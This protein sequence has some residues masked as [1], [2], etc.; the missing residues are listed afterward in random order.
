[1]PYHD[2][3]AMKIR[4]IGGV[5]YATIDHPPLNLLDQPLLEELGRFQSALSADESVRVVVFDSADPDFFVAHGDMSIARHPEA[6]AALA[7]QEP[8]GRLSPMI[9]MFEAYRALPQITIAK[10]RGRARGAG[11]EFLLALDLRFAA[12]ERAWF[13]QPEVSMG[14]LPGAGGTQ[15]LPRAVGRARA[16]EIIAGSDLFDADLAE[17]YGLINRALPPDQ[18]DAFTERLASR[19]ASFPPAAVTAAKRAVEAGVL[20]LDEGLRVE[21]ALT[22]T[23]F[24]TPEALSLMSRALDAGAQTREGEFVLESLMAALPR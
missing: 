3:A 12:S 10:V 1:M 9:T 11:L 16:L 14:I 21:D 2:Y 4:V 8:D 5:A 7:Q 24:G 6:V 20:P 18:L 23:L 13:G 19:I 22:R 17:R 15:Y